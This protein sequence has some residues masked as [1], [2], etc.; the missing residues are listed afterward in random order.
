MLV[1]P[2][3]ATISGMRRCVS[4]M[5][6]SVLPQLDAHNRAVVNDG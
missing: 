3:W 6:F 1:G 2:D 4:P 5:L